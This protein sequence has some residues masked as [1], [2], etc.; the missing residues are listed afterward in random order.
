MTKIAIDARELRTSTGRY[1]ER[2]LH[3]LQQ[4]D[5]E[6]DYFV[7]LKPADMD[8]WQPT[9]PRFHKI[10]C[11]YKEFTFAEQLGF[12]WQLYRLNVDLMHFAVTHQPVLYLKKSVTTM[13]DLTTLRFRNPAKNPIVFWLKL[14]A[15]KPVVWYAAHKSKQVIVPTKFVAE[16]V[17]HYTHIQPDKITVTLE[18]A[19]KIG[20][21]PTPVPSVVGKRYIMYVGRPLPHKNLWRLVEAFRKLQGSHPDLQLVLAGKFYGNYVQTAERI[22][23]EHITNIIFTDF[24]SEAELRWLY[25]HAAAY[26]FPSLSEGFGLP[27]L[28][29]M[30]YN[31][32]VISSNATCLPE[33]YGDAA[34][35]FDPQSVDDMADKIGQ[36]ITDGQLA[37][38]LATKGLIRVH[39]FSWKRM[40]EQTLAVYQKALAK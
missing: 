1:I 12:A 16:D 26:I 40:A 34:L 6:H 38:E 27:G 23:N 11:P 25:E 24:V 29:A 7:L 2:L 17:A 14:Q 13:H 37:K 20:E 19:D 22:K 4:I 28:E 36:V 8:G 10:A 33:V 30:H 31:V 35:Y 39:N 15:F 3:Y 9:N 18:S 21:A 5:N 32:P